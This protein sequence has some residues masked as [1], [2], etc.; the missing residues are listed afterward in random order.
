M[1][2]SYHSGNSPKC[3]LLIITN[4]TKVGADGPPGTDAALPHALPHRQF[5]VQ[6]RH[7]LYKKQRYE[8]THGKTEGKK[9]G[10]ME[11]QVRG[12]HVG[13]SKTHQ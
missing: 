4:N 5:Q 11:G 10:W 9:G 2:A 8:W 7:A 12:G 13:S 1:P 6:Q 3:S